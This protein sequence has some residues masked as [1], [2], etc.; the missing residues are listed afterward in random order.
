VSLV[1]W[2]A[3][4]DDTSASVARSNANDVAAKRRI[5]ARER[6]HRMRGIG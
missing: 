2:G 5:A 3:Y 1:V 6:M 4:G